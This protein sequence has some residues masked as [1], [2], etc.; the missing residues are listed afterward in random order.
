LLFAALTLRTMCEEG[1]RLHAL[2]LDANQ[3]ANLAAS[4]STADQERLNLF[5]SIACVSL[6]SLPESTILYGKGWPASKKMRGAMPALE[7]ARNALNSYVHP[8]YGSHIAALFPERTAAA[9]LLLEAVVAVYEAFFALSWTEQRLTGHTVPTRIGTFEPWPRTVERFQIYVL[10]EVRQMADNPALTEAMK[11]PAVIEWLTTER[12]DLENLLRDPTAES[13]VKDLPRQTG[14]SADG[15]VSQSFRMWDGAR[16]MDVLNLASAR[17]A[18]QLMADEF[19]AGAPDTID[20]GRWLRFNA[21]SLQLA[22]LLDQMKAAAFK[23]QLIRQVTQ[24]NVLGALLCVRSL[25]EHR[26][27]AVWLPQE[28]GL[29]LDALAGEL[30]AASPLPDTTAEVE[31]ALAKFLS[32]HS[33]GS[34][35][36]QRSWVAQESG[37]VRTVR[38]NL[39]EIAQ[40]AFLEED[41]FHTFYALASAAMHGRSARGFELA[42]N[43]ES[44][45]MYARFVGLLVLER[46]CCR[47]EDL[48]HLCLALRQFVRLDHAASFRGTSAAEIDVVARQV[49][50]RIDEALVPGDDYTGEGTA[51]DPFQ[52]RAHLQFHQASRAHLEKLGVDVANCP[53]SLEQS[54]AGHLC[55]RWAAPDRDYWVRIP[56][57][58]R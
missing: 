4:N 55:D 24:G 21:L 15:A 29:S 32:V 17:R 30:R 51:E 1:Q 41:R 20:Q 5:L 8:N 26:A 36:A 14:A 35:E 58:K 16:P 43:S 3:V 40:A 2:D 45:T 50:G 22:V 44:Q 34:N 19:P 52:F 25:I 39:G 49:F 53:R 46:L 27:L 56:A 9:R 13:L 42:L 47:E 38:L 6:D 7:S 10:P 28:V 57:P 48:D 11:V 23:A 37:S 33:H 18:E 31:R 12:A 54:V